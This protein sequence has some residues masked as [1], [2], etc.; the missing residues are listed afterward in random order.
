[1]D[2]FKQKTFKIRTGTEWPNGEN[3]IVQFVMLPTVKS[4]PT[5]EVIKTI[6][7]MLLDAIEELDEM[8]PG[9]SAPSLKVAEIIPIK[10]D[11]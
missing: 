7:K 5:L 2:I 8:V 3:T 11:T 6:K 4:V 1:M 10:S 9:A